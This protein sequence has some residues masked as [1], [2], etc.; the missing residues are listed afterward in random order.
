[1][2]NSYNSNLQ[3]KASVFFENNVYKMCHWQ[4]PKDLLAKKLK[5]K[6][7]PKIEVQELDSPGGSRR[8]SIQPGSGPPSR[9]GSLIPPEDQP[10]RPSL[11]IS[12]EVNF[13]YN[14]KSNFFLIIRWKISTQEF[15]S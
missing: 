2:N 13:K 1:M 8:G 3:T 6:E 4:E 10:R 15:I 12:D 14:N 5:E 7:T 11:L 9:R